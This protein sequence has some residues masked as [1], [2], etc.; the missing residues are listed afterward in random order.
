MAR[1]DGTLA[2]EKGSRIAARIAAYRDKFPRSAVTD[3]QLKRHFHA[4]GDVYFN[5]ALYFKVIGLP[6]GNSLAD[7]ESK[8]LGLGA[9]KVPVG[10][11]INA[12][13]SFTIR[14]DDA[15]LETPAKGITRDA[16]Y[17]A[18]W[19]SSGELRGFGVNEDTE[20]RLFEP[21]TAEEALDII[22]AVLGDTKVTYKE[23]KH[24][25]DSWT[26]PTLE[27]AIEAFDQ[28]QEELEKIGKSALTFYK[29]D[30][31][32]VTRARVS[33]ARGHTG[34]SWSHDGL[35]SIGERDGVTT[36]QSRANDDNI[37]KIDQFSHRWE[38]NN[39]GELDFDAELELSRALNLFDQLYRRDGTNL[40][41]SDRS[42]YY[43][44]KSH[45]REERMYRTLRSIQTWPTEWLS[46][47]MDRARQ[48]FKQSVQD[49]S[50]G[51]KKV[52]DE[53]GV[54]HN[55]P[56]EGEKAV[57]AIRE[58]GVSSFKGKRASRRI[59]FHKGERWHKL[60]LT[61]KQMDTLERVYQERIDNKQYH[62][63]P[64][65]Y[66]NKKQW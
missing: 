12:G 50:P 36:E 51:P 2:E 43:W 5:G 17:W 11:L 16:K 4:R 31:E 22:T 42:L 24:N 30:S 47:G 1:P 6:D 64:R 29:L 44:R 25:L 57:Y 9:F 63:L 32:L 34:R 46:Q 38:R 8:P 19:L 15:K 3:N 20:V 49:C 21:V 26:T 14:G 18:S 54:W 13:I 45:E 28:K 53:N 58:S 55:L 60:F 52:R 37:K 33:I 35:Y 27:S 23:A 66:F 59:K 48:M 7:D 61:R 40:G 10:E 65:A 56:L 41:W 62:G 39:N